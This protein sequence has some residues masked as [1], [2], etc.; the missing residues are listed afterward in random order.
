MRYSLKSSD[1]SFEN[2]DLG[3][4]L[5]GNR[6]VIFLYCLSC[7]ILSEVRVSMFCLFQPSNAPVHE[8]IVS[9][10]TLVLHSL[11]PGIYTAAKSW[12]KW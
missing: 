3:E 11:V 1:P 4:E 9:I 5:F 12:I 2:D 8:G 7:S 10:V 6:A